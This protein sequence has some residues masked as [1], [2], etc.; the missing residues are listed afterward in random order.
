MPDLDPLNASELDELE[1]RL[2]GMSLSPTQRGRERLL[3]AC[4]EAAGRAQL[5]RRVR[6][7]TAVAAVLGC[8]SAALFAA[9]VVREKS[10]PVAA[11]DSKPGPEPSKVVIS[12]STEEVTTRRTPN[13]TGDQNRPLTV[14]AGFE[15]LTL[16]EVPTTVAVPHQ[17][18]SRRPVE[19]VLTATGPPPI[20]L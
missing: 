19:P 15:E 5:M 7:A 8:T 3:Y 6:G 12:T 16:A 20:D 1:K 17:Q 10:P 13:F 14:A 4:G 18:S 2:S 11:I 9:L